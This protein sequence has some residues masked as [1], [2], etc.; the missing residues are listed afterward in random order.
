MTPLQAEALAIYRETGNRTETARRMGKSRATVRALID[1]A[2]AWEAASP[3]RRDAAMAS[4]I[5][6]AEAGIA[7]V[8]TDADGNVVGRSQMVKPPKA[9]EDP[10][11]ILDAIM[12]GLES[13]GSIIPADAPPRPEPQ[14]ESLL[15]VSL[16]DVHIGKLCVQSDVGY[17]YNREIAAHRMVEGTKALLRTAEGSGVGRILLT[18]GNDVLHVDNARSTTTSG[19]YQDTDGTIHQ[20]WSD[21]L[22][23]YVRVVEE[24]ANVAPVDLLYV[25]SNH[26]WVMGWSLAQAV[27][28]WFRNDPR[29]TATPY[30]LSTRHR[31]YYG[32]GSNLLQITHGDGAKD[33]DLLPLMMAEAR[34]AMARAK[35][36]YAYVHHVHHKDRKAHGAKTQKREKDLIGMT[37]VG[38]GAGM[39]EGEHLFI[40]A[41]RSPSPPDGWHD[42]NGYVNRQAVECF[43]HHPEIGQR[44]RFTEWF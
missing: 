22:A 19:T 3:G 36:L 15:N 29:V 37:V 28:A 39:P 31:K 11:R 32:F 30:N 4:G 34:P 12:E 18:L 23:A 8:K 9:T 21:A 13:V 24:C 16:A 40:E 14:G 25:P 38:S 33:S 10:Q 20:M 26:D 42:R 7:W 6:L 27:A 43:I 2:E 17:T 5:D 1:R 35:H 44:A 41:V